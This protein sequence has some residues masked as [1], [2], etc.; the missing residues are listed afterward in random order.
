MTEYHDGYG[1]ILAV[2]GHGYK[3]QNCGCYT[4]EIAPTRDAALAD[5]TENS[6]K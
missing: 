1:G 3:C 4:S 2:G 6:D 5:T